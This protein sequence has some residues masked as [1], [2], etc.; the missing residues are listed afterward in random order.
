MEVTV[1]AV[2]RLLT[3][4]S[5]MGWLSG[6]AWCSAGI[7]ALGVACGV[8]L[9][10]LQDKLLYVPQVPIR[11]PDDN[12]KG[13]LVGCDIVQTYIL[14]AVLSVCENEDTLPLES[15]GEGMVEGFSVDGVMFIFYVFHS[16]L[17]Q[18]NIRQFC[19]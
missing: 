14:E 7:G 16:V 13:D 2:L 15:W 18:Q 17:I 4:I 3:V 8:I 19:I 12:P 6:F 10:V 9:F 1:L 5:L 11:D